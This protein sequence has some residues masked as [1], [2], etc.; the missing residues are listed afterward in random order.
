[1]ITVEIPGMPTPYARARSHGR[2]RFHGGSH[3]AWEASAAPYLAAAAATLA[4]PLT[5]PL[6]VRIVAVYPR[7][8]RTPRSAPV[9]RLVPRTVRSDLDN[10]IKL[11]LDCAVKAG[12]LLDDRHVARIT[13][14][15]YHGAIGEGPRVILSIGAIDGGEAQD[16]GGTAGGAASTRG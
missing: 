11:V 2:R 1:M 16:S 15:H 14:E 13:A 12:L 10:V 6:T 5:G 7:P 9:G 4:E 3:A 8:K